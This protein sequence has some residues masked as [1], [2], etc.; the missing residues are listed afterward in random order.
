MPE[1]RKIED[2]DYRLILADLAQQILYNKADR[3]LPGIIDPP[4]TRRNVLID[5]DRARAW[6]KM[7]A[8]RI[9]QSK[10]N[11]IPRRTIDPFI[12]T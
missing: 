6:T 2:E 5:F 1:G 10:I 12:E 7:L 11:E 8:H 4:D 3:S 9:D